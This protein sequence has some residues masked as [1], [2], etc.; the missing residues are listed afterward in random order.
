MA[1]KDISEMKGIF[2]VGIGH[3]FKEIVCDLLK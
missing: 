1:D 2:G 3:S